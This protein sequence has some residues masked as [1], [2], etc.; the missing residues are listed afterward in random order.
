MDVKLRGLGCLDVA[1]C[2][3]SLGLLPVMT[4]L[5]INSLPKQLNEEALITRHGKAIP[6]SYFTTAKVTDLYVKGTASS[7]GS[8]T[9]TRFE[10]KYPDGQLK[11]DTVRV[12][13][14]TEVVQFI[15]AHL[16]RNIF[17]R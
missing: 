3:L 12:E 7:K 14:N 2:F 9:G 4:Y 16:P 6:W 10:L 15:N 1:G 17:V 8:Y 13:N 11:F 5:Q